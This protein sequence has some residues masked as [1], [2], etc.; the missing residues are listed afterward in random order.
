MSR[1][2]LLVFTILVLV[3]TCWGQ[4]PTG[5]PLKGHN[6]GRGGTACPHHYY[7]EISPV[8]A[9]AVCCPTHCPTGPPLMDNTGTPVYC[10][11]GGVSCPSLYYCEIAPN[12]AWAVCC[13]N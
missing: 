6:C 8:D 4:C 5:S 11:R 12:D 10:G 1:F 7:C 9:Y 2:L 3:S 13:A